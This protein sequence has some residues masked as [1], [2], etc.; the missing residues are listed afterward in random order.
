MD[1]IK[2]RKIPSNKRVT[3]GTIKPSEGESKITRYLFMCDF[4]M[5]R[6]KYFAEKTML[7]G[8]IAQYCG[9]VEDSKLKFTKHTLSDWDDGLDYLVVLTKNIERHELSLWAAIRYQCEERG[10]KLI[11]HYIE[12]DPVIFE[13]E[14][15][16]FRRDLLKWN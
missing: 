12:D 11:K 15:K 16:K 3:Y 13:N 4:G 7:S 10:V 1:F 9:W 6:S 14:I 5:S 8:N 2:I